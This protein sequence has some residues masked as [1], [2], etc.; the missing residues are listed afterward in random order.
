MVPREPLLVTLVKLVDQIPLPAASHHRR[1]GRPPMYSDRLLVK[2]LI[3]MII[4]RLDTAY[5][6]LALLDQD[7]DVT[8]AR[9]PLLTEHSRFPSRRTWERRLG[10]CR[11][12][13]RA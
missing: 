8:H 2:A 7:T 9:R 11:S 5:S 12:G 1:R 13:C 10:R 6:L 3:I 4:R